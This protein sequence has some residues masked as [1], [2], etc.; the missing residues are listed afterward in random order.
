MNIFIQVKQEHINR[1]QRHT[2][3]AC[4]IALAISEQLGTEAIVG[5]EF[6]NVVLSDLELQ[7]FRLPRSAVRFIRRFDQGE[8]VAPFRFRAPVA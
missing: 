7:R 5:P 4:P 6:A 1:G 3:T 8:P 2:A